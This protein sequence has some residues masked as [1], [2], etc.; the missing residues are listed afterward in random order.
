MVNRRILSRFIPYIVLGLLAVTLP[1]FVPLP[2][3]SL[4]TKIL[5]FGLLVMSLD[6]AVGYAGLWSFCHAALFGVAAYTTGILITKYDIV[7]FWLTAPSSIL[8][9]IIVAAIFG[10]IALRV[11]LVYFLLVTF[12]LGQLVY[13]IA[14]RWQDMT[15]GGFGLPN[16]PYPNFGFGTWYSP[17]GMYYFVLVIFVISSLIL[18]LITK[19]PFGISLQG[20]RENEVRM[21]ALGYNTWLYKYIAFII[22]G[23][24]AGVAG[25]LYA[26]YNGFVIPGNLDVSSSGLLWL[27]LIIGGTGT[28]WGALFGSFVILFLQY[29]ISLFTPERWPLFLG[30]IFIASVMY[31]RGGIFPYLAKLWIKARQLYVKG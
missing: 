23:L 18:Y 1:L 17:G 8:V 2:F 6:L 3:V 9:A 7:I 16:I 15:G 4:I 12:A 22:S 26:H 21:R 14:V 5:I 10:F 29:E 13:G 25:V 28:L 30:A 20:I 11:S 19:S 31:L 24:F 27:M